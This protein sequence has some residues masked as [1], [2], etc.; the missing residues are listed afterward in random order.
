MSRSAL[1]RDWLAVRSLEKQGEHLDL[2]GA[3][4]SPQSPFVAALG[5]PFSFLRLRTETI[6][7]ITADERKRTVGMVQAR[8]RERRPE[9]V[10]TFIAPS[11]RKSEAAAP[12][13][14]RLLN[15]L[16][17]KVGERGVQRIYA[18][19]AHDP[20]TE[21]VLSQ[22]GFTTY[23]HED[24][25]RLNIPAPAPPPEA[26]LRQQRPRDAWKLARLYS[27]AT[28]RPVQQAEGSGLLEEGKATGN[29]ITWDPRTRGTGYVLEKE[30]EVVGVARLTRGLQG[31]WLRFWLD[32]GAGAEGKALVQAA[33]RLLRVSHAQPVYVAVRDYDAGLRPLLY[34]MGF[35]CLLSRSLMV[36]HTTVRVRETIPQL[37][38]VLEKTI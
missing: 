20:K 36:K 27:Q 28:P 4:L 16:T 3:L 23:S 38:T 5:A 7:T 22:A 6:V 34:D 2:E 29:K 1:L 15:E 24:I 10:I 26:S 14:Y 33:L 18:Q 13:W 37:A 19:T 21:Q 12:I 32:P 11:L 9:C 17:Q 25:F 35:Q 31:Y 8:T 30:G